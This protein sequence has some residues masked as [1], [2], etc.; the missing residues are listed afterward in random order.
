MLLLIG[1]EVAGA[2]HE[3]QVFAVLAAAGHVGDGALHLETHL[4]MEKVVLL[5]EG[6]LSLPHHPPRLFKVLLEVKNVFDQLLSD[7]NF[8]CTLYGLSFHEAFEVVEPVL[9]VCMSRSVPML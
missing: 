5:V 3:G 9:E 2:E 8:L 7:L 4:R 6:A 1:G